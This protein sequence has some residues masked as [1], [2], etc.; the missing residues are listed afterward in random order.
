MAQA[1]KMRLAK[2]SEEL[3]KERTLKLLGAYKDPG[4]SWTITVAGW[5]EYAKHPNEEVRAAVAAHPHRFT[6][7]SYMP[8]KPE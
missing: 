6:D 5:E 1:Q 7:I 2:S 3:D 8:P 4:M